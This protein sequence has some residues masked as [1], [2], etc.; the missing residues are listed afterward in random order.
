MADVLWLQPNCPECGTMLFSADG[1]VWCSELMKL[2]NVAFVKG[3][4]PIE[5]KKDVDAASA[6]RKAQ[7]STNEDAEAAEDEQDDEPAPVD[8]FD[9]EDEGDAR[10]TATRTKP[11]AHG[12]KRRSA[13]NKENP[14]PS[15]KQNAANKR[16]ARKK[17]GPQK[18]ATKKKK[19]TKSMQD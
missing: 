12:K 7:R 1:C 5:L 19:Q 14:H 2:V 9:E 6:V 17:E 11:S 10:S 3:E 18:Q 13:D 8:E 15:K 4:L 16:A